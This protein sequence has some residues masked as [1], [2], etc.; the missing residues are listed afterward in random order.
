M[1]YAIQSFPYRFEPL[2][3]ILTGLA[4]AS[5]S[6]ALK[7]LE[8]LESLPSITLEISRRVFDTRFQRK[9]YEQECLIHRNNFTIPAD[10]RFV[11]FNAPQR[12]SSREECE[13]ILFQT[14]ANY[15]DAFHHKIEL[16]LLQASGGIANL[17]EGNNILPDQVTLGFDLLEALLA[18]DVDIS[19]SMVIPTELSFEVV[20]RFA[21]PVLPLNVYKVCNFI[22]VNYSCC[23]VKELFSNNMVVL[24]FFIVIVLFF[25]TGCCSLFKS[26][27]ETSS[28]V[29]RRRSITNA[30]WGVSSF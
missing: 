25:S 22:I 29:S 3:K 2:S 28:F 15:W 11:K 24:K 13:V 18:A 21:Y 9:P 14:K 5:R 20:N 8:I 1:K 19:P 23:S 6:S 30:S 12:N 16:L 27:L 17:S 26:F 7:T 4:S 10:C